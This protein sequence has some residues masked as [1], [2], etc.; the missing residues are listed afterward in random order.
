[1]NIQLSVSW[2]SDLKF[3]HAHS[4]LTPSK[5]PGRIDQTR[6][7][8]ANADKYTGGG[9]RCHFLAKDGLLLVI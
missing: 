1:M 4:L 6:V 5:G 2:R 3:S 9:T 7:A 8:V